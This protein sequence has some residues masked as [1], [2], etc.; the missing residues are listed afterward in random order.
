VLALA[1]PD[2]PDVDLW[3]ALNGCGGVSNGYLTAGGI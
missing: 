3:V 1:Y 2:R